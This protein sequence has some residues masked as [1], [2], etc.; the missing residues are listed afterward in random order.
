MA[1]KEQIKATILEVAGNPVSGDIADLADVWA[2]AIVELD[3]PQVEKRVVA[4]AEVR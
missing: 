2:T 3:N 1:S 4:P